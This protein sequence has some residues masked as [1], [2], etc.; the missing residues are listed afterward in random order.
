[1]PEDG[2]PRYLS[3]RVITRAPQAGDTTEDGAPITGATAAHTVHLVEGALRQPDLNG[4]RP[5]AAGHRI[6]VT[7]C[8]VVQVHSPARGRAEDGHDR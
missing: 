4:G 3:A 8:H 2:S 6:V 5:V 1:M 7:E